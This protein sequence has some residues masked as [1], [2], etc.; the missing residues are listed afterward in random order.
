MRRARAL[1]VGLMVAVAL[2]T[3]TA[4]WAQ[5]P[6]D[7]AI[8]DGRTPPRLSFVD[9]QASF[10]RPGAPD[11]VAAQ[12]NTA[13]A[14]GD[15]LYTGS[16]GN[17]ELQVGARAFIRAWAT[18]SLGLV[19]QD[20]DFLQVK[21]T[22]GYVSLDLRT[23]EP[24]RVVEL[25]TPNAAFTI[26]RAGYYRVDVS[27]NRTSF[28]ARRG[29]R[30]TVTPANGQ[31]AAIAPSEEIVIDGI[32]APQVAG[33]AAP[34]LDD[35]DRW[36]YARTDHMSD[37]VSARYVSPGA[38][39]V[40]DLDR[41]GRWRVVSEYGSVWVPTSVPS[42][43]VPYS[44]GSW[45]WDPYYGW[46]WVDT[47]PW[48]WAPFHYGRWV[49][50]DGFW[51]W[52]PGPVLVRP[53][54]APALV[55]FFGAGPGV[56]VASQPVVGWIALGWGE[57]VIRW[58]GAPR[59][60]GVPWW[61]GWGGPRVVNNVVIGRGAVVDAH[62]INLYRNIAVG[63]AVVA[64]EHQRFGHGPIGSNRV[65][66]VDVRGLEP[67]RGQLV[68]KPSAASLVPTA[69]RGV[70]PP[71]ERVARPVVATRA[72]QAPAVGQ[73]E[74]PARTPAPQASRPGAPTAVAPSPR[75]VP[76]PREADPALVSPRPPFGQS[77][78]ERPEPPPAPRFRGAE[79]QRVPA[80]SPA[81]SPSP[82]RPE[83]RA[84]KPEQRA[85]SPTP[86]SSIS[87]TQQAPP[88]PPAAVRPQ[89]APQAPAVKREAPAINESRPTPTPAPPAVRHAPA[90]A[91]QVSAPRPDVQRAPMGT[92]PGESANRLSPGRQDGRP[93]AAATPA[94]QGP[95][96]Q[97][98][99]PPPPR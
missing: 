1:T 26:D 17:V 90:P 72:P 78:S 33:Y 94:P 2:A 81:Q 65:T 23:L 66:R 34:P 85:A 19:N 38:Y 36:N 22:A 21:V 15:E 42:G 89:P 69:V 8:V 12:V 67:V 3:T 50:V 20:A 73:I 54:Y 47:A 57:P 24:G 96:G 87:A 31:A 16:P 88:T 77:R 4:A 49:F 93:P 91:P 11:W 28:I 39:G 18:T 82:A 92:L 10:W 59:F 7:E 58:W 41:Y 5:P 68:V 79:P 51:G 6:A 14:P 74:T 97:G 95:K 64:V 61:G 35:W 60:I 46:T 75:L 29:G 84:A 71:D 86:Q 53:A 63:N 40:S 80:P 99:A 76:A 25:D 32:D 45:T 52:A 83:Q 48:G 30:A 98:G 56:V 13:L 27:A 37:A 62:Q 9:G 44:T 43:W 70:R 55:A